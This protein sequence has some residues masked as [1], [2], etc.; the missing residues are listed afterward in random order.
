ML[1]KPPQLLLLFEV[2]RSPKGYEKGVESMTD[3]FLLA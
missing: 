2:Q 3:Y 1:G